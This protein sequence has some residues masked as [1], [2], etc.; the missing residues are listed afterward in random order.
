MTAWIRLVSL[1]LAA[2]WTALAA[3]QTDTTDT[4]N[5]PGIDLDQFKKRTL[6]KRADALY[7]QGA[8]YDAIPYYEAAARKIRRD[9]KR[10]PV[11]IQLGHANYFLRDYVWAEKWYERALGIDRKERDGLYRARLAHALKYQGDYEAAIEAYASYLDGE[12]K[13][14][15]AD[16]RFA[17]IAEKGAR[18]G[19]HADTTEAE[20]FFEVRNAGSTINDPFTEFGPTYRSDGSMVFSKILSDSEVRLNDGENEVKSRLYVSERNGGD[21]FLAQEFADELN[22]DTAYVGNPSFSR[23]GRVL[24][25]TICTPRP[26]TMAMRCDIHRSVFDGSSWSAP[27]PL[28]AINEPTSSST[29]PMIAE[30]GDETVLFFASDRVERNGMDIYRAV[31]EEDGGFAPPE[32]VGRPINTPYDDISPFYHAGTETLFFSSDGH[33]GFGGFDVFQSMWSADDDQWTDPVNAGRP[34]NSSYDDIHLAWNGRGGHGMIVSNRIGTTPLRSPTCCDDIFS[35]RRMNPD[36]YVA[37]TVYERTDPGRRL[38]DDAAVDLTEVGSGLNADAVHAGQPVML[39]I[40]AENAY[41]LAISADG[42]ETKE[43]SFNTYDMLF[44]D[45]LHYD[46]FLDEAVRELAGR[47]I[48][49][50]Y[51]DFDEF[52]LR[53]DAPDTLNQVV[54]FM[55]DHPDYHI[56]VASHTD[57][58]GSEEYNID[59]SKQR[60]D[61]VTRYLVSKEIAEERIVGGHYGESRPVAPNQN[62]D[63]TDNEEGRARN[64]RTEFVVIDPN[65]PTE[66]DAE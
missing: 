13:R 22:I 14:V 15:D 30:V 39:S 45:T 21:W 9:R 54:D 62:P 2:G 5:A 66:D 50:V 46:V 1:L 42:F 34:I 40:E 55:I 29:H 35:V 36:L 10:L 63:G 31:Q 17:R 16:R 33:V 20:V 48:G 44:D 25:L 38:S 53:D 51:W 60:S 41:R 56:E 57:D 26:G 37:V 7:G 24:Y 58:K 11:L 59:L 18:E 64:R 19:L 61:A 6:L 43:L 65:A 52:K 23:D 49:T 28:N 12:Y 47:R 4:S 3:A 32:P 8:F 27:T